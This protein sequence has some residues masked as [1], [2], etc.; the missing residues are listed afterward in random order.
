MKLRYI[1]TVLIGLIYFGTGSSPLFGQS[2]LIDKIQPAQGEQ[3]NITDVNMM[4]IM[5]RFR[6]GPNLPDSL[7]ITGIRADNGHFPAGMTGSRSGVRVMEDH[8]ELENM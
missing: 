4:G 6:S 8:G 7:V 5:V 3:I 1:L 2:Y